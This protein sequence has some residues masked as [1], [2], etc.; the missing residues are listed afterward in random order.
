[1]VPF[2]LIAPF[3]EKKKKRTKIKNCKEG[4]NYKIRYKNK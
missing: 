1:L 2:G 4:K 3:L